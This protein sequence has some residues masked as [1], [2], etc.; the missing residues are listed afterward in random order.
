MATRFATGPMRLTLPSTPAT[1]GHVT[2]HTEAD[3]ASAATVP[4][5]LRS[6]A[7]LDITTTA[8]KAA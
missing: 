5:S 2:A 8:Q 6:L 3:V 4:F 7:V 1:T